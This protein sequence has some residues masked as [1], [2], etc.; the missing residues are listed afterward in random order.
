MTHKIIKPNLQWRGSL[1][2]LR[3]NQV[4]GIALHHM[5]HPT[6][7]INQVHS[8]HLNN[9]WTG[10]G[11]GYWIAFDGTIYEG[12]GLNQ[13][14]GVLN[15]NGHLISVGFQGNYD[16]VSG[17]ASNT[18]MTDLQFN[19][20]VWLI[21]YLKEKVPTIKTV[22]GHGFWQS[23]ACPGRYFPLLEMKS[24][25][26]RG[27]PSQEEQQK[28]QEPQVSPWA[29]KAREFVMKNG[30]SDGTRPKDPMTREEAW[31]MLHRVFEK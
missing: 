3:L 24:G 18:Q 23:T 4:D 31:T 25:Q 7:D 26:Y 28:P 29:I 30:I 2:P 21:K 13:N 8:W 20:G 27:E 19:A 17:V 6:A 12:R 11:Y 10:L 15:H 22:E 14:A 5:A 16:I 9:G 1:T